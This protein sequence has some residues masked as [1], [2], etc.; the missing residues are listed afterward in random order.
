MSVSPSPLLI[1]LILF[2]C[3]LLPIDLNPD[4]SDDLCCG[5]A[6]EE[7]FRAEQSECTTGL[8][9]GYATPD[10]RPLLWKT[11]DVG[12]YRQEYHY[13]DDG[14][15]P[16]IGLTYQNEED[17]YFAGI[18]TAGFAIENSNSYNLERGP[19]GGDDD[20][21]IQRLALA[22]CRTVDDFAAILDSTNEEGRTLES[23]YGTFD[24]VGGAVMF[25]AGGYSYERVDAAEQ[26]YGFVVRSNFSY[27]GQ[28][29]SAF[30]ESYYG[31]NRHDRA[32]LLWRRAVES[33]N[34]TPLYILQEVVRDLYTRECNPYPL[35]FDGYCD[36]MPYGHVPHMDAI[37]RNTSQSIFVGQGVAEGERPDDAIIWAMT[38]SPLGCIATPLWVRAGSVP[39]AYDTNIGSY[40]CWRA[41][42]IRN[43]VRF[44]AGNVDTWKLTNPGGTGIYDFLLPLETYFYNKT[45]R[46]VDSPAFSYERLVAFQ[47]EVAQQAA[48]SLAAWRPTYLVTEGF[49][50][51]F[52]DNNIVLVWSGDGGGEFGGL[53]PRGYTVYRENHP[54]REGDTGERIGFVEEPRF[55]DRNPPSDGAF[56]RVAVTF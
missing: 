7:R 29:D 56:Y 48:D 1:T 30:N 3:F 52:E 34:L 32:Y 36:W 8:A 11:R 27:S 45:L 19:G 14:R 26:R 20:G 53:S 33:D 41:D 6:S 24:A 54:F 43:W 46:F 25:E 51:I 23:N 16:F 44:P 50:A 5:S 39:E 12:N 38:G 18:N 10:G 13:V 35:P 42:T 15:I 49:E 28:A 37:N 22:T 17:E 4:Y 40:L 47:S 21:R 31:L 55:V 2:L 9:S